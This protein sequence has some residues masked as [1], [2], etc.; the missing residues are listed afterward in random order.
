MG[1]DA[2]REFVKSSA[3]GLVT[4]QSSPDAWASGRRAAAEEVFAALSRMRGVA[5]K[6]GQILAQ[7]PGNVGPEYAERLFDLTNSVPPMGYGLVKTQIRSELGGSPR[8]VF[9]RFDNVAFAAASLGQVHRAEDHAGSALAVKVQYPG[10]ADSVRADLRNV[11]V[12][13]GPAQRLLHL[14]DLEATFDEAEE[15]LLEELDYRKE[16]QNVHSFRALFGDDHSFVIPDVRPISTRRVLVM[17]LIHG[18]TIR[19]YLATHPSERER[20]RYGELVLRFAWAS[21]F[22]HG[23]LHADTN[24][25]NYLF[26]ED[27]RLGVVDFGCVQRFEMSDVESLRKIVVA[28]CSG[29]DEDLH[30]GL[31]ESGMLPPNSSRA[32]RDSLAAAMSLYFAPFAGPKHDFGRGDYVGDVQRARADFHHTLQASPGISLPSRWLF[33]GRH[34]LGCAYLLQK[35]GAVASYRSVLEEYL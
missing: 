5:A 4:G 28:A 27:G 8:K 18:T 14:A 35:L 2:G 22:R 19:E 34:L 25:G 12:L 29:R 21:I 32:I 3:T 30:D 31:V 24:P 11:R 26:R 6:A 17:E 23:L 7:S 9:R 33:Y 15:R 1:L 20:R 13:L 16:A 10:V